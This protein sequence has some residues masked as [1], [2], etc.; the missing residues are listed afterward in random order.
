[1]NQSFKSFLAL[2]MVFSMTACSST[3]KEVSTSSMKDGSYTVEVTG[4]NG[5]MKVEVEISEGKISAI[6]V[7]E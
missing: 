4:H 3:G 7:D 1:M 5:P 2:G 6:N